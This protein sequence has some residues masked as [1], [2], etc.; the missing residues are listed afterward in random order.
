M[1]GD[2]LNFFGVS[3]HQELLSKFCDE[4]VDCWIAKAWRKGN[5]MEGVS[6][7]PF[8]HAELVTP[9]FPASELVYADQFGN[10]YGNDIQNQLGTFLHEA[11]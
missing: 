6:A 11:P 8:Y 5:T 3:N 1:G 7:V 2:I 9:I 4:G 10:S